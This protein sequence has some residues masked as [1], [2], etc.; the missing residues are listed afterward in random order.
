MMATKIATPT[1]SA[2]CRIMLMTPEP[3]ANEDDGSPATPTPIRVGN[4]RPTPMP[5]GIIPIGTSNEF[6]ACPIIVAQKASPRMK[7]KMPAVTTDAAPKRAISRPA[8]NSE[9]IGTN[10]GPGA[11]ARP[12]F[13][14]DH[15]HAVCAHNA[16]DNNIAPKA[17]E[18][19]AIT[20]AAPAKGLMRNSAGSTNGF[21][22]RKQRQMNK[23]SSMTAVT[24]LP[25][26]PG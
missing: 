23:K 14:A 9:V 24:V 1:A 15:P 10:S 22:E 12:V 6:G 4:V 16:D 2:A 21:G 18:Y 13:S 25:A 7:K 5:I 19:G 8:S 3:V 17:A 11:M 26:M 20:K